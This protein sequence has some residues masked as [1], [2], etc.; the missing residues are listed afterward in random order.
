MTKLSLTSQQKGWGW[1]N[2]IILTEAGGSCACT[3]I[4]CGVPACTSE[5]KERSLSDAVAA[6]G[7]HDRGKRIVFDD[8]KTQN[9]VSWC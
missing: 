8:T 6:P 1:T 4:G 3:L 9:L 7:L 5:N 2:I